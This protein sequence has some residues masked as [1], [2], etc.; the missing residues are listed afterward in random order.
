MR[1]LIQPQ[2][3]LKIRTD[4]PKKDGCAVSHGVP[5]RGEGMCTGTATSHK[6]QGNKGSKTT[7]DT[8]HLFFF[9]SM[10]ENSLQTRL[11]LAF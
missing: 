6:Y 4:A 8:I 11:C 10:R 7:I 5:A 1:Y 3:S 9:I 2:N